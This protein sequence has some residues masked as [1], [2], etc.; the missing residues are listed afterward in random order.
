M[1]STILIVSQTFVPDPAGTTG[2]RFDPHSVQDIADA[3]TWMAHRSEG[4]RAAMGRRAAEV[5]ADW[6]PERFAHGTIEALELAGGRERRRTR[7]CART[8]QL[9]EPNQ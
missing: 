4:E 7:R 8:V 9:A 6:G 1:P 2:R 3:L 5:V